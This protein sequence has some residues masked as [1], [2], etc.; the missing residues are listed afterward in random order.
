M[1]SSLLRCITNGNVVELKRKMDKLKHR[2]SEKLNRPG[3]ASKK[4]P[5]HVACSNNQIE[6]CK[7]L[8]QANANV[9]LKSSDGLS[10]LH[11]TVVKNLPSLA[12]L[13]IEQ[14]ADIA[15]ETSED[16]H[17]PLHLSV[18]HNRYE[19]FSM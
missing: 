14:S 1:K 13:L 17:T 5:L 19:I 10:A 16:G 8:L 6:S 15:I 11:I 2:S 9:N 18:I 3:R 4:I 12:A 7:I